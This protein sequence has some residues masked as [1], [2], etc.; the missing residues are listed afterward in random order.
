M[1][2]AG[3]ANAGITAGHKPGA[4]YMSAAQVVAWAVR[5]RRST[6]RTPAENARLRE[7]LAKQSQI[8]RDQLYEIVDLR[9]KIEPAIAS[10]S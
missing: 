1:V 2:S 9:A 4:M 3:F 5:P 8:Y 7:Q 10:I 6:P